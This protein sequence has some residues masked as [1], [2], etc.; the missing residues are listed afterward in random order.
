MPKP[1]ELR[2]VIKILSNYGV[3]FSFSKKGKHSG[4]FYR[5]PHSFPVKPMVKRLKF[6]LM[7]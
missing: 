6:F 2:K 1:R 3:E 4:K 7:H 5:G